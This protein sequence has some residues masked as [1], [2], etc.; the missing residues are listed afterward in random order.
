[1]ATITPL[2]ESRI[3]VQFD[4]RLRDITSGQGAIFYDGDICLGGGIIERKKVEPA[5]LP[6]ATGAVGIEN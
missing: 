1:M 5:L 2:P 6:L 4:E 3:A